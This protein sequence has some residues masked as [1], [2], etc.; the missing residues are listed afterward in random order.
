[1]WE[2][3]DWDCSEPIGN[4][5]CAK[6]CSVWAEFYFFCLSFMVFC[7]C[8]TSKVFFPL[9]DSALLLF[10]GLLL[11]ILLSTTFYNP[12]PPPPPPPFI[13]YLVLLYHLSS[14]QSD[15]FLLDIPPQKSPFYLDTDSYCFAHSSSPFFPPYILISL[16]HMFILFCAENGDS[17]FCRYDSTCL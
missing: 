8:C 16:F 3:E 13:L 4:S 1:M 6:G 9:T 2:K 17:W 10:A 11:H 12:P 14:C 7:S 5:V 15:F